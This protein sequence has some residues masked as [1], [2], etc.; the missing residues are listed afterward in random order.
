MPVEDI[1]TV[2]HHCGD[3]L[4]CGVE[5]AAKNEAWNSIQRFD[6]KSTAEKLIFLVLPSYSRRATLFAHLT[7]TLPASRPSPPTTSNNL[8]PGLS[9]LRTS[10]LRPSGKCRQ[11]EDGPKLEFPC[12]WLRNARPFRRYNGKGS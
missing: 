4:E 1:E 12:C 7:L 6:V 3:L 10:L 8:L 5:R 9:T 2:N 11:W